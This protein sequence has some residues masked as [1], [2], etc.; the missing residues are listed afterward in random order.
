MKQPTTETAK[1]IL[2]NLVSG[3][4]YEPPLGLYVFLFCPGPQGGRPRPS[5][6]TQPS[7]ARRSSLL[8]VGEVASVRFLLFWGSSDP[9]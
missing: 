2:K 7:V 4:R 5:E 3:E 1:Q 9:G 6:A 8:G